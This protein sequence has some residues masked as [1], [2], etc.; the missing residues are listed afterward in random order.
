[1]ATK[2]DY[3]TYERNCKNKNKRGILRGYQSIYNHPEEFSLMK[4]AGV[5]NKLLFSVSV[6][7]SVV[8]GLITLFRD[9]GFKTY[10]DDYYYLECAYNDY[11]NNDKFKD[12]IKPEDLDNMRFELIDRKTRESMFIK[13]ENDNAK[14][15][16]LPY[17]CECETIYEFIEKYKA[18]ILEFAKVDDVTITM[19]PVGYSDQINGF[20]GF[21][22]LDLDEKEEGKDVE[23]EFASGFNIGVDFKKAITIFSSALYLKALGNN[24][25]ELRS[26]NVSIY[27][28]NYH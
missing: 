4:S 18:K 20:I 11:M 14:F 2:I 5:T 9:L 3:K 16:L 15:Y 1:M 28:D 12:S 8:E 26:L 21:N 17:N 6:D 7:I 24:N 23:V 19:N 13:E 25:E 27:G 22:F 10:A